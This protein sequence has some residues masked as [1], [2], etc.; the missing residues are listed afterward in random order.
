MINDKLFETEEYYLSEIDFEKDPEVDSNYSINLRYARYWCDGFVKPLSKTEFKK[1]YEK[2]EKKI[3]EGKRMV[4]F[5]I[6]AKVDHHLIGFV[7]INILWNHA[8]GWMVISI[9]DPALYGKAERQLIPLVLNY[10]FRE[11]NLYRLEVDL[12]EYEEHLGKILEEN[13]FTID[14]VNRSVIYFENR[15]WNEFLYGIL[16]PEWE[17]L[18]EA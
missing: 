6:R 2:I 14:A 3:N 16:L 17:S 4:H 9:G 5:A 15:Y 12:P 8:V 10:A 1:K 18:Q 11:L 7:K 13:G